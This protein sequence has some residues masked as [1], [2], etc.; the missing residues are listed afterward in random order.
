MWAVQVTLC[1]VAV[2][3]YLAIRSSRPGPLILFQ[4]GTHLSRV[5]LVTH[6]REALAQR[7]V[8]TANFSSH[9]FRVGAATT[10]HY[11]TTEMMGVMG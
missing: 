11:T 2:L 3:G 7:G 8:D 6:V 9:S 1:P 10:R 5:H 4:N